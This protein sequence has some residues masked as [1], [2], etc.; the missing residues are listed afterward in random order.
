MEGEN[1]LLSPACIFSILIMNKDRKHIHRYIM[2][3]ILISKGRKKTL[4]LFKEGN[5]I[6]YKRMS[7]H[8]HWKKENG[9]ASNYTELKYH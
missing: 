7:Y 9:G 8:K 3:K 5:K 6:P 2:E 4:R 1:P